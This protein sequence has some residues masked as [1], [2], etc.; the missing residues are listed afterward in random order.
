MKI[1]KILLLIIKILLLI[2][3]SILKMIFITINYCIIGL[4]LFPFA[5]IFMFLS[6]FNHDYFWT[7]LW[8]GSIYWLDKNHAFPKY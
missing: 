5:I 1:I 4:V 8:C 6:I 3:L 2:I 7:K